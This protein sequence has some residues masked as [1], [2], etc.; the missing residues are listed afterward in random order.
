MWGEGRG[1]GEGEG[2][3]EGRSLSVLGSGRGCE[4]VASDIE[5]DFWRSIRKGEKDAQKN[6][7]SFHGNKHAVQG[8]QRLNSTLVKYIFQHIE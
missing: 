1:R 2:E 3:G 5:D 7:T 8:S 4:G 6:V